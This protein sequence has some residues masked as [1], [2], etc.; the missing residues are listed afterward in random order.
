MRHLREPEFI[1]RI[2]TSRTV[3]IKEERFVLASKVRV[4]WDFPPVGSDQIL[5]ME[6]RGDRAGSLLSVN[7]SGE[8]LRLV[9]SD[10]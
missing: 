9:T 3:R 2:R 5:H 10:L 8:L 1:E 7:G 4:S 6:R